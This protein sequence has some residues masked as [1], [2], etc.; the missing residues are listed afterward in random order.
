MLSSKPKLS[1]IGLANPIVLKNSIVLFEVI[2]DVFLILISNS[3]C[4]KPWI[5]V[6]IL[7]AFIYC[8]LMVTLNVYESVSDWDDCA[9]IFGDLR[10]FIG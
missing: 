7:F 5:P 9:W 4:S 6:F 10:V 2:I 1:A 3:H 8:I